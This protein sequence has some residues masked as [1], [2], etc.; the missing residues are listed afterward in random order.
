MKDLLEPFRYQ[1]GHEDCKKSRLVKHKG[2]V[3]EHR[4]ITRHKQISKDHSFT[5]RHMRCHELSKSSTESDEI[6]MEEVPIHEHKN[7]PIRSLLKCPYNTEQG[8]C[9][10]LVNRDLNSA[11]LIYR[12]GMN[13][14]ETGEYLLKR[15]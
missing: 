10:R 14:L 8:S 5:D 12:Q 4:K 6:V 15:S 7:Y 13:Y 11:E 9:G 1:C 3:T 2:K